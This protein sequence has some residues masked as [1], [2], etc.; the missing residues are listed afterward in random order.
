[1]PAGDAAGGEQQRERVARIAAIIGPGVIGGSLAL[2]LKARHAVDK[3]IAVARSEQTLLAAREL[4]VADQGTHDPASAVAEADLVVLA[5]PVLT[6]IDQLAAIAPH[7]QPGCLVTD[8]GSTKAEICRKARETLSA[9]VDFVGGHPMAGSERTGVGAA[10]ADLFEG[11]AWVLTPAESARPQ[12]IDRARRLVAATGA[13]VLL[14]SPEEHD[15]L[16]AGVSH[17]PHL[18]A[19]ALAAHVGRLADDHPQAGLMAAGGFRDLTRV[20]EGEP[21]L[22]R[23]ILA[24]NQAATVRH[25]ESL[26]E[27]LRGLTE[28]VGKGDMA[29]VTE[30]LHQARELRR[31]LG[32]DG[33]V[34]PGE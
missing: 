21:E 32:A 7:L 22:W 34:G 6:I 28:M 3:V 33:R 16:A 5:T 2:A 11:A 13:R 27:A 20:A 26:I 8:V 9:G 25:L 10:R 12:A 4:G 24:T 30:F 19:A 15:E 29:A 14:L 1:M 18:L 31:R 23:D 17:V